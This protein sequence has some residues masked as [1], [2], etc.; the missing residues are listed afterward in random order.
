MDV[1]V[2]DEARELDEVWDAWDELA[3]LSSQPYGAPAWMTA[4]WRHARPRGAEL[5]TIV[6]RDGGRPIGIAPFFMRR[7]AAGVTRYRV[8]GARCSARVDLLALP[9]SERPVARAFARCLDRI[10]PRPGSILFDGL[11]VSSPWPALLATSWPTDRP[12]GLNSEFQVP[13][14]FIPADDG[15]FDGWL[16][17]QSRN[18]RQSLRRKRRR[19]EEQGAIFAR[20]TGQDDLDRSIADLA[21]LHRLRWDGRGGSRVLLPGVE[22]MLRDAGRALLPLGRFD[23]WRI[24]ID[25][26]SISSHLFLS[27]GAE[28]TYWLGGFDPEWA[29]YQPAMLSLVDATEHAFRAGFDR[30]DLGTGG[31]PYKLRFTELAESVRWVNAIPKGPATVLARADLVPARARVAA[32]NR[33]SP[34]VKHRIRSVVGHLRRPTP[35]GS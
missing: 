11:R 31:Q 12:L 30:I 5:R 16:S 34:T 27:A 2:I 25:G 8:L 26:R 6:V 23:I 14:P 22:R 29:R 24:E 10:R 19:L 3:T 32:A 9:G 20:V 1:S 15:G 7:T 18:F 4:W 21:R 17:Q 13:A 33:L 28:T 35:T